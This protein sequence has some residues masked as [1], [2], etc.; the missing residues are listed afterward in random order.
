L[1]FGDQEC[2]RA[3]SKDRTDSQV[4]IGEIVLVRSAHSGEMPMEP[5]S[6]TKER[7]VALV[8][9]VVNIVAAVLYSKVSQKLGIVAGSAFLLS[10]PGLA[11]IWFREA[12]SVTAFDRGVAHESPPLFLDVIGW[13]FLVALPVLFLGGFLP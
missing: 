5:L 1:F 13:L 2:R 10:L 9:V 12:L 7:V 3:L 4:P 6:L 8:V 11:I